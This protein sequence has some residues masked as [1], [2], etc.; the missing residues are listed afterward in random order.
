MIGFAVKTK[1]LNGLTYCGRCWPGDFSS[2]ERERN[3]FNSLEMKGVFHVISLNK[4]WARV[5]FLLFFFG[6]HGQ[7]ESK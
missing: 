1:R 6:P 7:L 2:T 5:F 4:N 3:C